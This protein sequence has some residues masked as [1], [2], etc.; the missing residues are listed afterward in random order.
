MSTNR[1]QRSMIQPIFLIFNFLQ[2]VLILC[3]NCFQQ[4][5]IQIWLYEQTNTRI[6]G[7]IRVLFCL[8]LLLLQGF[9][10]YM[11]IVLDNACELD[12]K[13]NTRKDL[14]LIMLKGDNVSLIMKAQS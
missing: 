14:G 3:F 10:E 8:I 5:R 6:E 2:K 4:T 12:I 7:I 9:D 13:K 11:N 1:A